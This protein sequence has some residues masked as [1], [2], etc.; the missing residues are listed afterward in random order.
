MII[1]PPIIHNYLKNL[2]YFLIFVFMFF[3]TFQ[4]RNLLLKKEKKRIFTQKI[5]YFRFYDVKLKIFNMEFKNTKINIVICYF[6]NILLLSTYIKKDKKRYL[7]K[8]KRYSSFFVFFENPLFY[9]IPPI[10]LS[11]AT[12]IYK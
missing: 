1:N 2:Q 12:K 3:W 6:F 7:Q 10:F 11:L 4:G 8:V 9:R 5:Y